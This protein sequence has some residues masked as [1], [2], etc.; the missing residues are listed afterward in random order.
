MTGGS[1]V[2]PDKYMGVAWRTV[3]RPRADCPR[4]RCY[5]PPLTSGCGVDGGAYLSRGGTSLPLALVTYVW[6]RAHASLTQLQFLDL[7]CLLLL[8]CSASYE[9]SSD[10]WCWG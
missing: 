8:F 7:E 2:H 6:G 3:R 5:T 1:H 10:S 4:G 9:W